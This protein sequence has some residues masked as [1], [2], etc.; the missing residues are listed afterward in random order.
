MTTSLLALYE[1]IA[2]TRTVAELTWAIGDI[3]EC[4]D[5]W[6]DRPLTDPYV[7]KLYA[8]F[9]AFTVERHKRR[10]TP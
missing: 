10:K 9:D 8:E 5:I 3:K 6:K 1:A 2:K 4:L 7:T